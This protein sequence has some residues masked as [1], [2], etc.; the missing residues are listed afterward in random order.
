MRIADIT[1]DRET[2]TTIYGNIYGLSYQKEREDFTVKVFIDCTNERIK[3][4]EYKGTNIPALADYLNY[5]ATEN[6]F[7][8][9]V[10]VAKEEDWETFVSRGY[11]LEGFIRNYFSGKTGYCLSRFFSKERRIGAFID[12]EDEIL[13]QI[14]SQ[15]VTVNIKKL[16]EDYR[17][18]SAGTEDI[19]SLVEL[20][21]L[22]FPSYPTPLNRPEYLEQVMGTKAH[23]KVIE[24][25]GKIISAASGEINRIN[26]AV[27]L[28]DCATLPDYRGQGLM[29]VLIRALEEEMRKEHMQTVYSLSRALSH[30]INLVFHRHGYTFGGRL[31]NNC[32]IMGK[33]EDMNLWVK[34]I[35]ALPLN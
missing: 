17:L 7:G 26:K 14:L 28:T 16:P 29:S 33:Y 1:F 2:A 3:I 27:E 25:Q 9:V 30:G 15:P 21:S 12:E 19:P 13:Q 32:N 18:R 5:L 8:K 6:G 11:I 24:H 31:I 23:F 34:H 20:F 22:V 10:L 4:L 35:E